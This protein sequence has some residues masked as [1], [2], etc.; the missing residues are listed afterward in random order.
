MAQQISLFSK[1]CLL[2]TGI[3]PA[4]VVMENG[5]ISAVFPEQR[6]EI[7]GLRGSLRTVEMELNDS[8][9]GFDARVKRL[10]GE[11]SSGEM[12]AAGDGSP[13]KVSLLSLVLV[14]M[15]S[16]DNSTTKQ[17]ALSGCGP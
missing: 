14:E 1:R 2:K 9:R 8:R 16:K 11:P 13:A 10:I 3:G 15:K 12:T 5:K 4:T 7:E 6:K 17:D